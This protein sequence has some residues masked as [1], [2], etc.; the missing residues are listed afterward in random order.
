VNGFMGWV[1]MNFGTVV[2]SSRLDDGYLS[3]T[4]R[5]RSAREIKGVRFKLPRRVGPSRQFYYR[6][7]STI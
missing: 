4:S 2:T 5:R 3:S 7:S 1:S 6:W